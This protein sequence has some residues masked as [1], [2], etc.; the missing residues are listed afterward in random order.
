MSKM[1]GGYFGEKD[2]ADGL[3]KVPG[4]PGPGSDSGH[5][6][7]ALLAR[8]AE[9]E[10]E[11]RRSPAEHGEA[12]DVPWPGRTPHQCVLPGGH[13]VHWDGKGDAWLEVRSEDQ[14]LADVAEAERRGYERA[15]A[16]L[17]D[18]G[19]WVWLDEQPWDS[20]AEH[21]LVTEAQMD[22]VVRFLDA[23]KESTDG[24]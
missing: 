6:V 21:V 10:A 18:D 23:V 19:F 14:V 3:P 24:R 20:Y 2:I 15:V 11:R 16:R 8:I 17:R 9:L 4:G 5:D 7:P 1:R 13:H 12:C 22:L